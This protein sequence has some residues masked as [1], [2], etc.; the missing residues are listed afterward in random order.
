MELVKSPFGAD[1][2]G[3]DRS[4]CLEPAANEM[5]QGMGVAIIVAHGLLVKESA[6]ILPPFPTGHGGS[7]AKSN[8]T[9]SLLPLYKGT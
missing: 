2:S 1:S 4:R 6:A 9:A 7:L 3:L 8:S 5:S